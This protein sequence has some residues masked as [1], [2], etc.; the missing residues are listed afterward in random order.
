MQDF[1]HLLLEWNNT[2]EW[3]T[4]LMLV[5][6]HSKNEAHILSPFWYYSKSQI[7]NFERNSEV[8]KHTIMKKKVQGELL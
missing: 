1:V 4:E 8:S 5:T 2:G 3:R 7:N 6:I